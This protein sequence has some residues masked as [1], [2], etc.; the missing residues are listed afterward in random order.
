M[1]MHCGSPAPLFLGAP[2]WDSRSEW[3][4]TP[5]QLASLAPK[6]ATPSP[7]GHLNDPFLSGRN[8]NEANA[9]GWKSTPRRIFAGSQSR[10]SSVACGS[11]KVIEG[12]KVD[13]V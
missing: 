1:A 7:L 8:Q 9:D 12:K 3:F 6:E 5:K 10:Q 2:P 13:L 4:M 11:E